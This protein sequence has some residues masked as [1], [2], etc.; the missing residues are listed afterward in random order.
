MHDGGEDH[1][2]YQVIMEQNKRI[3]VLE[4]KLEQVLS[5]VNSK[6]MTKAMAQFESA[7]VLEVST[8]EKVSRT[9]RGFVSLNKIR[10]QEEGF[11]LDLT[12]ITDQILAMGYPTEGVEAVYRNPLSEAVRFFEHY[13]QDV[14][15]IYNLCAEPNRQYDDSAFQGRCEIYPFKDHNP[16]PL[17][18]IRIFCEDVL[19][20][21]NG[22]SKKVAAIHCKAGKGRTGLMISALLVHSSPRSAVQALSTF[23]T[24]RTYDGKGVTI[25]SQKRYVEYYAK[26]R[27]CKDMFLPTYRFRLQAIDVKTV[28]NCSV[29]S[30]GCM[31]YFLVIEANP[32][33]SVVFDSRDHIAVVHVRRRQG[34][35]QFSN[36]DG[37]NIS[38]AGNVRI[39]FYHQTSNAKGALMWT[40]WIH[41]AFVPPS[42]SLTLTKN[43][44]DGPHKDSFRYHKKFEVIHHMTRL[45]CVDDD[46]SQCYS[47]SK[48]AGLET[49]QLLLTQLHQSKAAKSVPSSE[50]P[51]RD[52]AQGDG[53][54]E[55]DLCEDEQEMLETSGASTGAAAS[56]RQGT[57]SP[58]ALRLKN[59][60]NAR[61]G[62][63][64]VTNSQK[65]LE[66]WLQFSGSEQVDRRPPSVKELPND[67]M[68]APS[69]DRRWTW[70]AGSRRTQDRS[71]VMW[72]KCWVSLHRLPRNI[73]LDQG[74]PGA[75]FVRCMEFGLPSESGLRLFFKDPNRPA[76]LKIPIGD[77][78][79]TKDLWPML[80]VPILLSNGGPDDHTSRGVVEFWGKGAA[81]ADVFRWT[82]ALNS[83]LRHKTDYQRLPRSMFSSRAVL[84]CGFMVKTGQRKE[85]AGSFTSSKRRWFLLAH[86]CLMYFV[87]DT[88]D[89][90]KGTIAL[91]GSEVELTTE[92]AFVI[93]TQK[94][95]YHLECES[96]EDSESWVKAIRDASYFEKQAISNPSAITSTSAASAKPG[97]YPSLAEGRRGSTDQMSL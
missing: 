66:S 47:L 18:L 6:A 36:L 80:V 8:K 40:S 92:K 59:A 26:L 48:A 64:L 74:L 42:N 43:E 86:G 71:G 63:D 28:P 10:F 65:I 85:G 2:L 3:S 83:E 23:G 34:G 53:G 51:L 95:D 37:L 58:L 4:E 96:P 35:F 41:T 19:H 79:D 11:D 39:E 29:I 52:G 68:K 49:R 5:I 50:F 56:A 72:K 69:A 14:Y 88:G 75:L 93:K 15:K 54:H 38:I 25:P 97:C 9:I 78:A 82:D 91:F 44:L 81:L 60:G 94:K 1:A 87:N 55:Y 57:S 31:P 70:M 90:W 17:S 45:E 62:A 21:L 7:P 76:E 22:S 27:Q 73:V 84:M 32:I 13:H 89:Q 46:D 16:P 77:S 67:R 24:K 33:E 30:G 20:W 61:V 12:Y